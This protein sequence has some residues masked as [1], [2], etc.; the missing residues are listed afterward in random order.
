MSQRSRSSS[1]DS[2]AAY[3]SEAG[4]DVEMPAPDD[5]LVSPAVAPPPAPFPTSDFK[6]NLMLIHEGRV[7]QF[8]TRR[9]KKP[10]DPF[11][12]FREERFSPLNKLLLDVPRLVRYFTSHESS[13]R[14]IPIKIFRGLFS[15]LMAHYWAW[16]ERSHPEFLDRFLYPLRVFYQYFTPQEREEFEDG[17]TRLCQNTNADFEANPLPSDWTFPLV[18]TYWVDLGVAEPEL[19]IRYEEDDSSDSSSSDDEDPPP[20][21]SSASALTSRRSETAP[22]RTPAGPS[23]HRT[24]STT[25]GQAPSQS[26]PPPPKAPSTTSRLIASGRASGKAPAPSQTPTPVALKVSKHAESSSS[27]QTMPPPAP[28][29]RLTTSHTNPAAAASLVPPETR[30]SGSQPRKTKN[31]SPGP[32]KS[33]TEDPLIPSDSES[34]KSEVE[35]ENKS[36]KRKSKSRPFPN[37]PPP[38]LAPPAADEDPEW[39][40]PGDG[41]RGLYSNDLQDFPSFTQEPRAKIAKEHL[42][43]FDQRAMTL[44]LWQKG[45]PT[46]PGV[47]PGRPW[48]PKHPSLTTNG[49]PLPAHRGKGNPAASQLPHLTPTQ[50][51][52]P[53][54]SANRIQQAML[55]FIEDPGFSCLECIIYDTFCEFR[56]YNHK[57]TACDSQKRRS[58]SFSATDDQLERFRLE[59]YAW[60][61]MGQ[62]R[63]WS[64]VQDVH[65]SFIRA[66]TAHRAAVLESLDF[67]RIFQSFLE[68]SNFVIEHVG[69]EQF[70]ARFTRT[71][72]TATFRDRLA[73]ISLAQ[74]RLAKT[75][76]E[77]STTEHVEAFNPSK[78]AH[79]GKDF[80]GEEFD[81]PTIEQQVE[82]QQ[83]KDSRRKERGRDTRTE[84][85]RLRDELAKPLPEESPEAPLPPVS[86]TAPSSSRARRESAKAGSSRSKKPADDSEMPPAYVSV[87]SSFQLLTPS[88]K[89]LP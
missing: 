30:A 71:N 20:P 65:I 66:H 35:A 68:H 29:K 43:M 88:S 27:A 39:V 63:S 64:L 59:S 22:T 33:K 57:C 75:F 77:R 87:P 69:A 51:H 84:F 86:N 32:S 19:I 89:E 45:N 5:Q 10:L 11:A 80:S 2:L 9:D 23:S 1:I 49:L 55:R 7:F 3:G 21:P 34:Q 31:A 76:E 50:V 46:V 47:P 79:G 58:C 25:S 72:S 28:P 8:L 56:G 83:A 53:K 52:F 12:P 37:A 14:K 62:L 6:A 70:N 42:W 38:I 74:E 18:T 44:N 61:E 16:A 26:I 41:Y 81:V 54:I 17:E 15:R 67:Q 82:T 60:I 4:S 73:E 78:A 24:P 48:P 13:R 36:S 85:E 40:I